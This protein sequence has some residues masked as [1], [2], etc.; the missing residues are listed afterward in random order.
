MNVFK[1]VN[2][3]KVIMFEK[4]LSNMQVFNSCFINNME[5]PCI[6]KSDKKNYL[7]ILVYKNKKNNLILLKNTRS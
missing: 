1:V 2:S 7:V 3:N 5:D 6:D 4:V